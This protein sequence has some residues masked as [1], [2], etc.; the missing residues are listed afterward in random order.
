MRFSGP[1]K[2]KDLVKQWEVGWHCEDRA[3]FT[4]TDLHTEIHTHTH[5]HT[6]SFYQNSKENS[7]VSNRGEISLIFESIQSQWKRITDKAGGKS[8]SPGESSGGGRDTA[9]ETC[10][11]WHPQ[12]SGWCE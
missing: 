5:Q 12:A 8:C 2:L 4:C 10:L 1:I 6:A 9:E 7:R 3:G 11:K